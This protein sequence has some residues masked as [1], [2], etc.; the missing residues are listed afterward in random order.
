[1]NLNERCR[2]YREAYEEAMA[3]VDHWEQ[4]LSTDK[5]TNPKEFEEVLS[6]IRDAINALL[7]IEK[8]L[9]EC[10]RE[11]SSNKAVIRAIR[12]NNL[13]SMRKIESKIVNDLRFHLY[14]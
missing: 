12:E 9:E 1:M 7:E 10:E 11:G 4:T 5:N 13:E 14:F 8:I 2:P 6:T 3:R